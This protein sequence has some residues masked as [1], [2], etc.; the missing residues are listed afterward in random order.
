M[1][2]CKA[3]QHQKD[4]W[5]PSFNIEYISQVL[6]QQSRMPQPEVLA[7]EAITLTT[8]GQIEAIEGDRLSLENIMTS[9]ESNERVCLVIGA[10]GVGKT[11]LGLKL[12]KDWGNKELLGNFHLLLYIPLRE[13]IA[14]LSESIDELLKYFDDN[15]NEGDSDLIKKDH[16]K[17]VLFI[18]DGWDE[19]KL[20]CRGES[21]F[22]PKLIDGRILPGCHIIVTSRPG[23][24]EDI[25]H[26]ANKVIEILGFGESHVNE[27]IQAYFSSHAHNGASKLISDLGE[28][29]NVASTCY[30]AINLAIVCHVY[31]ARG[32]SLPETLTE[33][34]EWF[35]I[36][37]IL[38]FLRKKKIADEICSELPSL[39]N[40]K[41]FYSEE[42]RENLRRKF[43]V[44]LWDT[45]RN[46][47]KLALNGV[48][49]SD[50]CFRRQDLV[51]ICNLDA[52]DRE[53]DGF[54]LLKPVQISHSVSSE[55]SYHF[56]HLSI[57]EYMAAFYLEMEASEQ[58]RYL[59]QN[60]RKYDAVIR[61]F[62]GINQFKSEF[63]R[64]FFR[65]VKTTRL[66]HFECVYE[67]QWK[68][69]CQMIA[70]QCSNSFK[71]HG[72]NLLPRQWAVLGY[73][74]A[75]SE[76]KWHFEWFKLYPEEKDLKCFRRHLSNPRSFYYFSLKDVK[77]K[78]RAIEHLSEICRSQV[79]LSEL[80][81]SN[82][83]L[84]DEGL[85][86][87]LNVL[88][89]HESL[90]SLTLQDTTVTPQVLDAILRLLP[91]LPKIERVELNF[92]KFLDKDYLSISNCASKSCKTRPHIVTPN[93]SLGHESSSS[94]VG[95]NEES[96]TSHLSECLSA[97]E[98]QQQVT[99]KECEGD[100][101]KI[102]IAG[103][104]FY[105]L[106]FFLE[107]GIGGGEQW[108]KIGM[109]EVKKVY[110]PT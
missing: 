106:N 57:Q 23:A 103:P 26:H 7:R 46:I 77:I 39:D 59:I 13:P 32:Y 50:L 40:T 83:H 52:R 67:G 36:H 54:G 3:S 45:L 86:T 28:Y 88:E 47:G 76:T 4:E 11:R 80:A 97:K 107:H 30:I 10:P 99:Q 5:P 61:F 8:K 18:L 74:M 42:F 95:V 56:L 2:Y 72:I 87:V 66:F 71:L 27:Y 1:Y 101:T 17:G 29:P 91:T 84:S 15:C 43:G 68:E 35:I 49:N 41:D 33:V 93:D 9:N 105:F 24:S 109:S 60:E 94:K 25:R 79:C 55:L 64:I 92:P 98:N 44:N 63:L 51:K 19:L 110:L 34:Y 69:H 12:C 16:G 89:Q 62:C 102:M 22:F 38:R 53:F 65:S 58:M 100:I 82:C 108:G 31:H 96:L 85:L 48:E 14:R 6:V 70:K 81:I 20:S 73:V 78:P 37:T 75:N 90:R 104:Y 21:Q